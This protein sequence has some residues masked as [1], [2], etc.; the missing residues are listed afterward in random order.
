MRAEPGHGTRSVSK[1]VANESGNKRGE[2]VAGSSLRIALRKPVCDS[3]VG[4]LMSR[5]VL[6]LCLP[7]SRALSYS[8]GHPSSTPCHP[9]AHIMWPRVDTLCVSGA[10]RFSRHK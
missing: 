7:S 9:G 5:Q 4:S 10:P 3:K 2:A 6:P 1:F 8:E